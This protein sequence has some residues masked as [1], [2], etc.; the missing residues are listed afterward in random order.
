MRAWPG[1]ESLE[2]LPGFN[3]LAPGNFSMIRNSK[4]RT[5]STWIIFLWLNKPFGLS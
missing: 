3:G 4:M 5:R 2:K 1:S